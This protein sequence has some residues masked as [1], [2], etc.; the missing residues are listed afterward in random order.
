LVPDSGELQF[1]TKK[2]SMGVSTA[3]KVTCLSHALASSVSVMWAC[4][5]HSGL[6]HWKGVTAL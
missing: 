5:L 6:E 4:S 1:G 3:E 2:I